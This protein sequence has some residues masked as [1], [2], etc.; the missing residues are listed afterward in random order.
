VDSLAYTKPGQ[1][2]RELAEAL[3]AQA[4]TDLSEV[5]RLTSLTEI[6]AEPLIEA[7][8]EPLLI[9]GNGLKTMHGAIRKGR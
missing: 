8:F 5:F 4:K 9:Y 3:S 6:L 7:G 1:L 2:A